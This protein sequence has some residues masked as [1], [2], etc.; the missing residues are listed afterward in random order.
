MQEFLSS[1]LSYQ[2]NEVEGHDQAYHPKNDHVKTE[3]LNRF[4]GIK[5]IA[6]FAE[7]CKRN[8]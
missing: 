7:I 6:I 5:F 4:H 3:E 8:L 1:A 2:E